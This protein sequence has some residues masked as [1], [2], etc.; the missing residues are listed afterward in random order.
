MDGGMIFNHT[1]KRLYVPKCGYYYISSQVYFQVSQTERKY[2]EHQM[3][4]ERNCPK[5]DFND[6]HIDGLSSISE[7][8]RATST[9]TGQ[10][11]KLCAGGRIY[12]QIPDSIPCCADGRLEHLTFFGAFLVAETSCS[13]PPA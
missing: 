10:I 8:S 5:A 2:V 3:R 4:V 7:S 6:F 13:W 12:I 11:V 1:D 9:Y